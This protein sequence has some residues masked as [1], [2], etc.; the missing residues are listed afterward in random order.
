[1]QFNIL[2]LKVCFN[3]TAV[4]ARQGAKESKTI[5]VSGCRVGLSYGKCSLQS[6][7]LPLIGI[8]TCVAKQ[9]KVD[10]NL[11]MLG[12]PCKIAAPSLQGDSQ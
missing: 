12:V 11:H 9:L 10:D 7:R 2:I 3:N 6:S 5:G 8:H 4:H 1:M